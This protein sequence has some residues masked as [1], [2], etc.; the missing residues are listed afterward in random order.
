MVIHFFYLSL[1]LFVIA[2]CSVDNIARD[3][4]LLGN[5]GPNSP[6]TI[7]PNN[8]AEKG[9]VNP[10]TGPTLDPD[11]GVPIDEAN[12]PPGTFI[13]NRDATNN[14]GSGSAEEGPVVVFQPPVLPTSVTGA[15]LTAV[16]VECQTSFE[17]DITSSQPFSSLTCQAGRYLDTRSSFSLA[18]YIQFVPLEAGQLDPSWLTE[19]E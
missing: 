8:G 18:S 12:L 7:D 16:F 17:F 11:D 10:Q 6:V 1:V 13:S 3:Q 4:I 9:L 2:G 19:W 5:E 14:G 15:H